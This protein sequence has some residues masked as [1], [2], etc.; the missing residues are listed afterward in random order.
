MLNASSVRLFKKVLGALEQVPLNLVSTDALDMQIDPNYSTTNGAGT[1]TNS[2]CVARGFNCCLDNQCVKNGETKPAAM[3]Q[4]AT[5]LESAEAQKSQN[6]LAYLNYPQLYYICGTS[7]PP[8]TTG[9]S[10]SGS[11]GYDEAFELL[12]KDNECVKDLKANS[13][14][15]PFHTELLSSSWSNVTKCTIDDEDDEMSF[16]SVMKRLYTTCGCDRTDLQDMINNCPAY[17]YTVVSQDATGLPNRIDCYTPPTSTGPIPM[18]QSVAV[19]SRSAPHRFFNTDGIEKDIATGVEVEGTK[20][21][22]LDD[23]KVLPVQDVNSMNAI[24]GQMSVSLDQALPAKTVAVE[25]DQIYFLSTTSGYYTPCPTCA[26]DSWLNALSAYP[27]SAT[28]SGLQAVGY[29]TQ[30]DTFSTNSTGGNYEDTI[31]GRAC[32]LPPTMIPF[33][34]AAKS[35]LNPS[36]PSAKDQRRNRLKAQAA[37]FVN[38][39][40]RDWF[41]FNKGALIGSFDGVTWFAVGK[42]R[43]VRSTSTKL[44]LAINAP[45]ADLASPTMHTVRVHAYDGITQAAQ[46]DYDPQYHQYHPY[47]NEAGNCQRNH[48]CATDTDCVTTLGW[49]YACADVKDI[50]T[51]WPKFDSDGNEKP[52]TSVSLTLDQ[53]LLQKKFPNSTTKRCVYRGAGAVCHTNSG[54]LSSADLNKRKMLTCAPNFYCSS[55][56]GFNTKVARYAAP[57]EDIPVARNHLFGKDANILGRPE[58]YFGTSTFDS[59]IKTVIASNLAAYESTMTN[60]TGL[61][62]PGKNLPSAANEATLSNP[63]NQHKSADASQRADYISQIGSCNSTLFNSVYRH[64][65]CPVLGSDENYEMFS[66]ATLPSG[67][68]LRASNQNGCGLESVKD[69]ASLSSSADTIAAASP[70]RAIEA[71][72]LNSQIIVD[73]TFARDACLR[74]AGAACHTDLDCTPNKKHAGQADLF[75][76]AFF[77]NDAEKNYYTEYLVCGQASPEPRTTQLDAYR[78]YDITL[79]KCCREIGSELTTYT[80]DVPQDTTV[81]SLFPYVPASVGLKIAI[82]PGVNPKDPKR[83]SRLATVENVGTTTRPILSANIDRSGSGLVTTKSNI[84]TP[85]QWKTLSE[86]NSDSCCGGGFIRKFSDGTNDWTR[87]DRLVLDVKNFSCLNSRSIMITHPEDA[88]GEYNDANGVDAQTLAARDYGDY[89]KDSTSTNGACAQF[90][91]EDRVADV[92]PQNIGGY[93]STVVVNTILPDYKQ[94]T[95]PDYHFKPRSADS[96]ALVIIN[97]GDEGSFARRNITIKVPSYVTRQFDAEVAANTQTVSMVLDNGTGINCTKD[98]GIVLNSPL[99]KLGSTGGPE[100]RYTYNTTSRILKVSASNQAFASGAIFEKKQVGVRF[101]TRVAGSGSGLVRTKPGTS[102]YYLR[103]LGRLELAGIPQIAHEILQCNDNSERLL[104]G[105]FEAGKTKVG[106]FNNN[107][108]SFTHTYGSKAAD[109]V[110]DVYQSKRFT[111]HHGLQ[112]EAIF[113]ANDFK[114]CSP[115]GKVVTDTGK[116]CSGFGISISEGSNDKVC[117]L[118]AGTNLMV[119]FNR[120]VSNE[121]SGATQPSG[122]GLVEEDFDS[123]TGEPILSA[124]VNNKIRS[125]GLAYCSSGKVRQGGALGSFEIEP[126]GSDTKISD[127]IYNFVDSSR[128]F[129]QAS[130]AGTTNATGYLTF[131][132]GFRWN[133]HLYCDD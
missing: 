96:N 107:A 7:V 126:Q 94:A 133:H 116:C 121:G 70:F 41:G 131:M 83:Y 12:K 67:Y 105:I 33:S 34:H 2:D 18:Q 56:G 24:L 88:A 9:S 10:T 14:L 39:Y 82:T 27:Q 69:T 117:S 58:N 43:I 129:G 26:K 51:N 50:K 112:H 48:F 46:V 78:S 90:S 47:Q 31:F 3:S 73:G 75:G 17:E 65:S 44:F 4:Y 6:P 124:A 13:S 77:G 132:D 127:R 125:L 93:D 92:L 40:Q 68:H 109:G 16:Q 130:N 97:Y 110:T 32:W 84:M 49:E 28:G 29:T 79:N 85:H 1:C 21:E 80:S 103:R 72:P 63:F 8:T 54:S 91:I 101:V 11:T 99:D 114:C 128:D 64:S 15:T 62:Q 20:F 120:F 95:N 115:L 89:C 23:G 100:C 113:S 60:N 22:Y 35:D 71:K 61:C 123:Q 19:D 30:R 81:S 45:F 111:T 86:A 36:K 38:G 119:Y 5:L 118:P 57:L 52:N 37:L 98:N 42:G 104:P 76:T 108:Y 55:S 66:A 87:K 59:S 122:S 53:I 25:L 102:G 74:R 106:E